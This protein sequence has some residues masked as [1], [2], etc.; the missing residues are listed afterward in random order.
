M[1]SNL[2]DLE[3]ELE[4]ELAKTNQDNEKKA[5]LEDKKK[6][7]KDKIRENQSKI[8]ELDGQIKVFESKR[9]F[10]TMNVLK[11]KKEELETLASNYKTELNDINSQLS[12][13]SE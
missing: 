5:E 1:G 9:N 12:I 8:E 3:M 7:L 6:S 13:Y 11:M 10:T 2:D 4:K